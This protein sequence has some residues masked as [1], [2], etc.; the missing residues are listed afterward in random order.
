M[1]FDGIL[2]KRFEIAGKQKTPYLRFSMR[3][4]SEAGASVVGDFDEGGRGNGN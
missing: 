4:G 1:A 3:P 2:L